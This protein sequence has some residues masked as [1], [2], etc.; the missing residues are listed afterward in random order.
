MSERAVV[1]T[2]RRVV[3]VRG[4]VDEAGP[5]AGE[6]SRARGTSSSSSGWGLL[7]VCWSLLFGFTFEDSGAAAGCSCADV[8]GAVCPASWSH[9]SQRQRV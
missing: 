2:Q 4:G 9:A 8:S 7:G 5:D 6:S 3:E 1:S